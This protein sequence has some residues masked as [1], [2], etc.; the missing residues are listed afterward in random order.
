MENSQQIATAG[1]G[2]TTL[3]TMLF[4][5]L[6]LCGVVAWSWWWVLSPIW[7]SFVLIAALLTVAGI[8]MFVGSR[9]T[10]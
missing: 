7:I 3:L 4:I 8:A 9:T 10:S 2:L 1:P 5:T 6:K